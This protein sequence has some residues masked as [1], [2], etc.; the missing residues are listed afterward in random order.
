MGRVHKGHFILKTKNSDN[1]VSHGLVKNQACYELV[2]L[3][4]EG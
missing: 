3:V 2:S 4:E 1:V